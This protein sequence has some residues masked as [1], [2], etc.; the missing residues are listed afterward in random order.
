MSGDSISPPSWLVTTREWSVDRKIGL[1]SALVWPNPVSFPVEGGKRQELSH[2][3]FTR[4]LT[5]HQTTRRYQSRRQFDDP[6]HQRE[7]YESPPFRCSLETWQTVCLRSPRSVLWMCNA[8][9]ILSS[10]VLTV[11]IARYGL[12]QRT[13]FY[14]FVRA[15]PTSKACER[16]SINSTSHFCV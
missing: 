6:S 1:C 14:C 15:C 5:T 13:L 8:C 4:P 7:W 12:Y 11:R 10:W 16:F 9:F 3:I 2:A